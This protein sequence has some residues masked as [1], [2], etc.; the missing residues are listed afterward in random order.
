VP[1]VP[2]DSV[3]ALQQRLLTRT[4]P[5]GKSPLRLLN[6]RP[7]GD[8][9][10]PRIFSPAGHFVDEE[11]RRFDF[12]YPELMKDPTLPRQMCPVPYKGYFRFER[13]RGRE[14]I[15]LRWWDEEES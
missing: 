2:A 6:P 11:G 1:E 12:V 10:I 13:R 14:R 15:S 8:V 5:T 9:D 3:A 4:F 7:A